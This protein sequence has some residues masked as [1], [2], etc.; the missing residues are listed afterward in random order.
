MQNTNNNNNYIS[1]T[2]SIDIIGYNPR[3]VENKSVTFYTLNITNNYSHK[4]WQV[5]KR[6]NEFDALYKQLFSLLPSVPTIP[7]KTLFTLKTSSAI[8]ERKKQL[9]SFL[10]QC[11][12]RKDILS[13]PDFKNFI[14]LL[15]N[16][17]EL[18]NNDVIEKKTFT[19]FPLGIRDFYFLK[20]E[21]MLLVVCCDMKIMSRMDSYISNIEMPWEN[22]KDKILPVGYFQAYRFYK[23]NDQYFLDKHYEQS[24]TEQTGVINYDVKNSIV[25][26]GLDSGL[27]YLLKT[28][29]ESGFYTYEE[30][31][32][33]KPHTNRVMGVELDGG[34]NLLYSCSTD[35]K[36]C[37]TDLI[38]GTTQSVYEAGLG[39][40]ALHLDRKNKRI[41]LTN[42]LGQI[43]IFSTNNILPEVITFVQTSSKNIIRGFEVN[44]EKRLIFT[45]T[46]NGEISILELGIPGKEKLTKE[47]S[48]F[49]AN[50]VIRILRYNSLSNE[51]YSGDEDGKI[52]VWNLQNGK[53][54]YVWKA[55]Q[56]AVT[57]LFFDYEQYILIS[58]GKDK[59][60][61][62]WDLPKTWNSEEIKN[63]ETEGLQKL[64]DEK[65]TLRIQQTLKQEEDDS[66][67]DSLNGWDLRP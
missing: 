8:E 15:K 62:V 59:T 1:S 16:C 34:R 61:R 67:E 51:L 39:Y 19:E 63:F 47:I 50:I 23:K 5:E 37:I 25:Q 24:F 12:N 36:F 28:S 2:I 58:G 66:S 40:T 22:T 7:K 43:Y 26:I 14:E 48:F 9:Q 32:R 13:N 44:E 27:I 65:A 35:K 33:V 21:Q 45:G 4:S 11:V 57:Q 49:T 42:R 29:A 46:K 17:P 64:N 53:P 6:Y 18:N 55:H 60:I 30:L 52:I 41:F 10:V 31:I 56:A 20:E 3:I 38:T 54:V